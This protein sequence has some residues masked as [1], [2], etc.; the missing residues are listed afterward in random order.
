MLFSGTVSVLE[1]RSP[2]TTHRQKLPPTPPEMKARD[3]VRPNKN[4]TPKPDH[5]VKSRA[6]KG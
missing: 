3:T 2:L 5:L 6:K 1:S 4:P